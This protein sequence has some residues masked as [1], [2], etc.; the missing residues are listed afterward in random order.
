MTVK[1]NLITWLTIIYNFYT[2]FIYMIYIYLYE[3]KE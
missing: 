2:T 3:K 1:S